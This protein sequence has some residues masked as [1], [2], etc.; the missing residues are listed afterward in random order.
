MKVWTYYAPP[1]KIFPYDEDVASTSKE[2][3]DEAEILYAITPNKKHAKVFKS[4]RNMNIFH[5]IE[6]DLDD[7]EWDI[8]LG[9]N[10]DCYLEY[11]KIFTRNPIDDKSYPEEYVPIDILL[12]FSEAVDIE[13]NADVDGIVAQSIEDRLPPLGILNVSVLEKLFKLCY[14]DIL[15]IE[16]SYS[17]RT[18]TSDAFPLTST[19]RHLLTMVS[20]IPH[21]IKID[22]L[23]YF[24]TCYGHTLAVE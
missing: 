17:G 10:R 1:S 22:E 19:D 14:W 11:H 16:I 18:V 15:N 8:L 13:D 4:M 2:Y 12:T 9:E 23:E 3:G 21:S 6:L 7:G 24:I 5:E 20:D